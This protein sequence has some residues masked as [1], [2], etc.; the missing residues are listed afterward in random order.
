MLSF[1]WKPLAALIIVAATVAAV[2]LFFRMDHIVITGNER[3]SE[4]RPAWR[5]AATS[6]SST[7]TM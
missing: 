7:S 5:R 2:T 1:L 4:Q 3:Y 6:T